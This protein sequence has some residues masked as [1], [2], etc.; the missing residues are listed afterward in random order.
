MTCRCGRLA[1]DSHGICG[2]CAET[3]DVYHMLLSMS[4]NP[5]VSHLNMAVVHY[6]FYLFIFYFNILFLLRRNFQHLFNKSEKGCKQNALSC[7]SRDWRAFPK[8]RKAPLG[9]Q[10]HAN[11]ISLI[12]VC[13][14]VSGSVI[15]VPKGG[16][17][18][19]PFI[20][21]TNTLKRQ[22]RSA[23]RGLRTAV[24]S[25]LGLIPAQTKGG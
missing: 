13:S 7:S 8:K 5:A 17:I 15:S 23:E 22:W 9:V 14:A 6:L 12:P 19:N 2:R 20:H 16:K 4:V 1:S 10:S 24:A 25:A 3:L 21:Q 11:S 18:K